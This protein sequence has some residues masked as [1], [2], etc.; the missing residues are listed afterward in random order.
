MNKTFTMTRPTVFQTMKA[1]TAATLAAVIAAVAVPQFFHM[2]GAA[3]GMGAALGQTLL[4]MHLP[5]LLV[6]LLA[7][8]AAGLVAGALGPIA[9]FALSG[10]P[11]AATL[12]FMI[13]E[14]AGYGLAAG[15]LAGTK[16]PAFAKVLLAQLAGRLVR[17]I[18]VL[19]AVYG[20]GAQTVAVA[21]IWTSVAAGLPGLVLQWS[22]LP[23]MLFWLEHREHGD[24]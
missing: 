2:L 16:L 5:I 14:L 8:P 20:L 19:A 11:S 23:L 13:L 10:M 12:P 21:S 4:P 17:A 1:R 6:G 3:S 15:L 18:A 22:L 24:A 7:G 9:S